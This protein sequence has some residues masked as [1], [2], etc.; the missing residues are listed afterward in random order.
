MSIE[1]LI[2]ENTSALKALTE[3]IKAMPGA[4]EEVS[5]TPFV[6][7]VK[8]PA[9][10]KQTKATETQAP[11]SSGTTKE[12]PSSVP[13]DTGVSTGEDEPLEYTKVAERFTR[14]VTH[15]RAAAIALLAEYGAKKLDQVPKDKWAEVLAKADKELA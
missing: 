1:Q 9:T 10:K 6:P 2:Q 11:A 15:D 14:F 7:Q 12:S 8:D 5:G 13:S 3:A 4:R